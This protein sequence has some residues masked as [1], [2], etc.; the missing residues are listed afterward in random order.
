MLLVC[1]M[2]VYIDVKSIK[3]QQ[4]YSAQFQ[5]NSNQNVNIHLLLC[6]VNNKDIKTITISSQS[7]LKN[8]E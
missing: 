7:S 1:L 2:Y 5:V 6:N 8:A 3:I 4:K